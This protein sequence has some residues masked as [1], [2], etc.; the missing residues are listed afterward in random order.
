[1][2]DQVTM[3][4]RPAQRIQRQWGEVSRRMAENGKNRE[5]ISMRN[6]GEQERG[7]DQQMGGGECK[8]S[9]GRD[10]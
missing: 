5:E 2:Q 1:M 4:K 9:M 10:R 6:V 8:K 3:G 7:R